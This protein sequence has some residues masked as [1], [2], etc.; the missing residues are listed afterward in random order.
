MSAPAAPVVRTVRRGC[1]RCLNDDH[2]HCRRFWG[3]RGRAK[4]CGCW[5][6]QTTPSEPPVTDLVRVGGTSSAITT[7]SLGERMEYAKALA[8]AGLLPRHFRENPANVLLAIEKGEALGIHHMT[9]IDSLHVIDGKVGLSS[10]L[11]RGLILRAGH[12]FDIAEN[13]A[14]KAAVDVARHERPNRVSRFEFTIEDA[15][16]AQLLGKDVWKKYPKAMLLARATSM[17]AR[18]VFADVLA[19]MGYTPEELEPSG[20][21]TGNFIDVTGT[22]TVIDRGTGEIHD[23]SELDRSRDAWLTMAQNAPD[24]DEVG[25]IWREVGEARDRREILP[26]AVQEVREVLNQR[27]ADLDA[28][29]AQ[30]AAGEPAEASA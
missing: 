25:R 3:A 26:A 29:A 5:C 22:A 15:R 7:A 1:D 11:M 14:E 8:Q 17:A 20:G 12:T 16:T 13:T 27:K 23:Q 10:E 2:G 19:G 30:D 6:R 28:E 18:A 24:L 9:A 21:A 4:F